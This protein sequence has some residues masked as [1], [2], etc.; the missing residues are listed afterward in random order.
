MN[1]TAIVALWVGLFVYLST[2][3][4]GITA[5]FAKWRNGRWHHVM[6]GLSCLTCIVALVMTGERLLFWTMLCLTLMPFSPAR[7]KRHAI[8]GTL[9]LLGYLAIL[10]R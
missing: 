10:F 4:L 9:G 8:I 7:A 3:V 6:F 1:D 2:M 5:S